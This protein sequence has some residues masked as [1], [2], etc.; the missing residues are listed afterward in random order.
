MTRKQAL[1]ALVVLLVLAMAPPGAGAEETQRE[2]VTIGGY[3]VQPAVDLLVRYGILNGDPGGDMRLTAN[4]TRAELA[5]MVVVA[6]GDLTFAVKALDEPPVFDDVDGHWARGYVAVAKRLGII[7]GY[8]DGTFRPQNPVSVAEAIT[9]LLR[10]VDQ[11]PEGRWPDAYIAAAREMGVLTD[12]LAADIPMREPARRGAVFL[13]AERTFTLV[14]DAQRRTLLQRVF[15]G[16]RP[17][18]SVSVSERVTT[19]P[20]ITVT[21]RATGAALVQ[22]NGIPAWLR[23]GSFSV[24]VPLATGNN[25]IIVVAVD[26]HGNRAEEILAVKRN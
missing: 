12:R 16:V 15:G 1:A 2:A 7:S 14:A 22:V 8:D 25:E 13:L 11:R 4:I 20:E 21:G 19:A 6:R 9:M 3:A 23:D 26:E 17:G 5:K 18:L 24:K 10:T